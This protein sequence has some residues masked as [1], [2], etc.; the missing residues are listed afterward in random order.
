VAHLDLV[1]GEGGEGADVGGPFGHDH[2]AGVA[3]HPGD[4][5]EGLLGALG[6]DHVAAGAVDALVPHQLGEDLAQPRVALPTGVLEGG[7]ALV[8]QHVGDHVPDGVEGQ[9]GREGHAPGEADDLR[10][11]GDGEQG[12]DLG[13]GHRAGAAGVAVTEGVIGAHELEG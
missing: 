5:V 7:R 4:E 2:V 10:T 12:S 13:G 1:L 8:G 6:D 9:R 11:G 3:E